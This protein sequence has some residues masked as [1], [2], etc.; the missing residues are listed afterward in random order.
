LQYEY[1]GKQCKNL[2]GLKI[3]KRKK[4]KDELH[5]TSDAIPSSKNYTPTLSEIRDIA[6]C[7]KQKVSE[8]T[9]YPDRVKDAIATI[10]LGEVSDKILS[11]LSGVA[12]KKQEDI[13]RDLFGTLVRNCSS[14]I[15]SMPKEIGA[16]YLKTFTE[17][18]IGHFKKLKTST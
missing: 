3:H 13:Y 8:C 17:L 7:A 11:S 6:K 15:P 10:D 2:G 16:L 12:F 14:L 18:L 5:E 1:C 4:H 9:Y